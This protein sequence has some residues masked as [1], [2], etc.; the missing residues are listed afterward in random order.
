[1]TVDP[2]EPEAL[3]EALAEGRG[4]STPPAAPGEADPADAAEQRREV[5]L[6]EDAP[7]QASRGPEVDP[8]DAAEQARE[9]DPGD[10]EYR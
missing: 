1:M 2:T 5:L 10:E 3:D 4:E 9:V 6:P 8:A 7:P